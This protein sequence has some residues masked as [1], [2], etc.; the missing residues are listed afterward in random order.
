MH[1]R[2]TLG[3]GII[4][5]ALC[6]MWQFTQTIEYCSCSA[7]VAQTCNGLLAVM[8]KACSELRGKPNACRVVATCRH[9][10]DALRL[11]VNN[12]DVSHIKHSPETS[13]SL[14]SFACDVSFT[15]HSVWP[16][17]LL[18]ARAAVPTHEQSYSTT[19]NATGGLEDSIPG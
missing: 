2:C 18:P 7:S 15:S 13:R 9:P 14:Q 4:G 6:Y 19:Q 8:H 12:D 11:A 16:G 3:T 10:A 5:M 17:R 1:S